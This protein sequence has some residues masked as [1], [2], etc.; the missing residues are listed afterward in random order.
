MQATRLSCIRPVHC[1]PLSNTI[2]TL[3]SQLFYIDRDLHAGCL[4]LI[5]NMEHQQ[6]SNEPQG[7]QNDSPTLS[8]ND[9][10][11]GTMEAME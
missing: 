2:P 11:E 7:E 10:A 3:N 9:L 4:A 8:T 5:I 1:R 6:H